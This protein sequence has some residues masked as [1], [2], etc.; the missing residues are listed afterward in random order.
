MNKVSSKLP[1]IGDLALIHT[2]THHSITYLGGP[3]RF[4]NAQISIFWAEGYRR[5]DSDLRMRRSSIKLKKK[6]GLSGQ[7]LPDVN[8]PITHPPQ[9]HLECPLNTLKHIASF[10]QH[11]LPPILANLRAGSWKW[12]FS[13]QKKKKKKDGGNPSPVPISSGSDPLMSGLGGE[14]MRPTA[15]RSERKH[16]SQH[17]NTRAHARS[18]CGDPFHPAG[19]QPRLSV[20]LPSLSPGKIN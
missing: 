12:T 18:R 10:F 19:G 14:Q 8:V 2:H 16:G 4:P 5:S 13:W 17:T 1:S 6:T 11:S 15:H 20:L 9:L 3:E 7:W